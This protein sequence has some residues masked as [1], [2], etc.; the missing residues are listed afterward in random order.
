MK[1]YLLLS[2]CIA[3][4][5]VGC[6]RTHAVRKPNTS[7]SAGVD[8]PYFPLEPGSFS[9]YE[10]EENGLGRREE[11]YTYPETRLITD[12]PCTG[13]QQAVYMD[14]RLVE[15]SVEWYSQDIFG[16]V[17]KM[18]EETSERIGGEFVRMPDS[19]MAGDSQV[20]PWIAFPA[21]L[22]PGDQF[23][24]YGVGTT[25]DF[26]VLSVS[27]NE[28]TPAGTFDN[29]LVLQE[30]PNDP[31]D[32]DIIIYGRGVGRVSEASKTSKIVL[33]RRRAK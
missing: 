21:E 10:G 28:T 25:D 1:T 12:I 33:V 23:T 26:L 8:H 5:L 30:N 7:F 17:W 13:V 9:V 6:S 32:S 22:I 18:G 15:I 27:M 24:G 31:N 2:L 29:C 20:E 3:L 11:E 4:P 14:G 16:N 19:W